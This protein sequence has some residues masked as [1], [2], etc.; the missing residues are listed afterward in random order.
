MKRVYSIACTAF[1][2]AVSATPAFAQTPSPSWF[3]RAF[4]VNLRGAMCSVGPLII[5]S[6][7]G[8]TVATVAETLARQIGFCP[9]GSSTVPPATAGD[10]PSTNAL[11]GLQIRVLA[12][13]GTVD[14]PVIEVGTPQTAYAQGEG[15][16]LAVASNAPGYLEVWSVDATSTTFIEGIVLHPDRASVVTLPRVVEGAYRFETAGGRDAVLLRYLPCRPANP[17]SFRP[18]ANARVAQA[19]S[20]SAAVRTMTTGLPT[21]PFTASI[22]L[23]VA[24]PSLFATTTAVAASFSPTSNTYTAVLPA[25]SN[26]PALRSLS[27]EIGFVRQ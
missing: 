3:E 2:V 27:T 4:R 20:V 7:G 10:P 25:T 21:C 5:R 1:L 6:V 22:P 14:A 26:A 17:Q 13:K 19:V 24:Q 9:S 16:G 12:V 15:F 18:V 23:N 8:E 11:P